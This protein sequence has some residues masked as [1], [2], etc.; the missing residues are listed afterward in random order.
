[1]NAELVVWSGVEDNHHEKTIIGKTR[2]CPILCTCNTVGC[3]CSPQSCFSYCAIEAWKQLSWPAPLGNFPLL[4]D[5]QTAEHN[6]SQLGSLF[7]YEHYG[8]TG[9]QVF[10][11]GYQITQT[12][13]WPKSNIRQGNYCISGIDLKQNYQKLTQSSF[14]SRFLLSRTI[15]FLL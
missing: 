13:S 10:E 4:F 8:N 7:C 11:G 2:S 9:C 1:M 15:P 5:D 14:R 12:D 6:Q 3:T